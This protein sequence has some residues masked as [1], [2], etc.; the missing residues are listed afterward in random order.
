MTMRRHS[1]EGE[2]SAAEG[3][4]APWAVEL[5]RRIRKGFFRTTISTTLLTGL[6]FVAYF[7]VQRHPAYPP[8]TMPQT[9]L[10]LD[11]P[12]QAPALLAYVSVWIYIG[13]GP[14]LQRTVREFA[15]YGLWLCGLCICGLAIFYF[16]PT[17]VPR[18]ILT[19][20]DFPGFAFLH[21]IDESS[22]A[23]PSMHVAV[24]IFTVIRVDEVLRSMRVP[25]QPRLIN[26]AWFAAI[27]Y[28]TLAIK[29]HLLV[30]VGAGAC[31]GLVFALM[32]LRWRPDFGRER[33]FAALALPPQS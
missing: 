20:T 4:L 30:D 2:P 28:S 26:A 27:A 16:W 8:I 12:F 17:Q 22:N 21:Q 23:C 24:A 13:F 6:F 32:S 19:A 14:G 7:W 1:E 18:S 15:V 9:A 33:S 25:L 31:L 11:I 3:F 29:Q 10:D 5:A